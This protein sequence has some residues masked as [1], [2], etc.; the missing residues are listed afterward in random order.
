MTTAVGDA[1]YSRLAATVTRLLTDYGASMVLE[2]Y[3]TA[4]NSTTQTATRT[5]TA[6]DSV[7]GVFTA[8]RKNPV[9]GTIVEAD[10]RIVVLDGEAAPRMRDRLRL[11]ASYTATSGGVMPGALAS[12]DF[13]AEWLIEDVQ[14][15]APGGTLLAHIVTV[16]K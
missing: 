1:L 10:Q 6:S 13:T 11:P 14:V 7:I 12:S 15:I 16:R 2:R 3:A 9:T 5:S 4:F 8:Q